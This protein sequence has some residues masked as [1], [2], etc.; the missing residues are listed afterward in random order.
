V[1]ASIK[2]RIAELRTHGLHGPVV[3]DQLND[4]GS[5]ISAAWS[6]SE[7][8]RA[9]APAAPSPSRRAPD[10]LL[11]AEQ[12]RQLEAL[13]EGEL[14]E[15]EQHHAAVEQ[16]VLERELQLRASQFESSNWRL[17]AVHSAAL[18]A[19]AIGASALSR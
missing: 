3:D 14:R 18:S 12:G 5:T 10:Q 15:Q 1:A 17:R 8:P 19:M 13:I 2:R 9:R 6:F 7:A 11:Q 16:D 4:A